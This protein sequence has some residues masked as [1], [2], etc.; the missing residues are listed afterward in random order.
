MSFPTKE[1]VELLHKVSIELDNSISKAIQQTLS[2]YKNNNEPP[3]VAALVNSLSYNLGLA[4]AE[5]AIA[6]NAQDIAP[7]ILASTKIVTSGI[8]DLSDLDAARVL[9]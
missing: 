3:Y 8:A 9:N 5:L 7:L 4:I 6:T 2:K 1:E